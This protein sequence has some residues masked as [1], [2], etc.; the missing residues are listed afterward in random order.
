MWVTRGSYVGHILIALW[1]S[2]SSGSASVT[3]FQP[4]SEM[5]V[6]SA[7]VSTL[8]V[9]VVVLTLTSVI[10]RV[11][12][13]IP[14]KQR[15][16]QKDREV[17]PLSQA[18]RFYKKARSSRHYPYQSRYWRYWRQVPFIAKAPCKACRYLTCADHFFQSEGS[19]VYLLT[20]KCVL[21]ET[22]TTW[23]G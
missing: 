13:T 23:C 15:F 21:R 18:N 4:C 1:V 9:T 3:H 17:A 10:H 5:A 14:S 20:N 12:T 2:G 19:V 7:P 16:I 6:I 8:K 11:V 22:S